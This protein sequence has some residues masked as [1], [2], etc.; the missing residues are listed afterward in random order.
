VTTPNDCHQV[1]K[2][3]DSSAVWFGNGSATSM[4]RMAERFDAGEFLRK[5]NSGAFDGRIT[6]ELRKLTAEQ[7]RHV[8]ALMDPDHSDPQ[9]EGAVSP[10]EMSAEGR[11]EPRFQPKHSA[12]LRVLGLNAVPLRKV[13]VLDISSSGMRLRGKL[14]LACGALVEVDFDHSTARGTVCQCKPDREYFELAV[15]V[16]QTTPPEATPGS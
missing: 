13:S 3:L 16:S 14:P 4:R 6:E 2:V 15:E 12:T 10:V 9:Q 8:A 7:L 11:R 1:L 5:L